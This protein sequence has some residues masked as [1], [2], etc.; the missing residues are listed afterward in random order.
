MYWNNNAIEFVQYLE[1]VL[2]KLVST[3]YMYLYDGPTDCQHIVVLKY[4]QNAQI[5]VL[6]LYKYKRNG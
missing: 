3:F 1:T 4:H 6:L 5:A 2:T